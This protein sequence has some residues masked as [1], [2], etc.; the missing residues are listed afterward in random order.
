MLSKTISSASPDDAFFDKLNNPSKQT[1]ATS[2]IRLPALRIL[3]DIAN[4]N[5]FLNFEGRCGGWGM[6]EL[7]LMWGSDRW[8]R[9]SGAGDVW[10]GVGFFLSIILKC[11]RDRWWTGQTSK[12]QSSSPRTCSTPTAAIP[13]VCPKVHQMKRRWVCVQMRMIPAGRGYSVRKTQ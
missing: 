7:A 1:I 4:L 3:R 6:S 13:L 9:G 11:Q 12:H 8:R 5:L 2:P 10:I